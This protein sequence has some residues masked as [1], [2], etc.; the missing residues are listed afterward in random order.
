MEEFCWP[1]VILCS[2]HKGLITWVKPTMSVELMNSHSLNAEVNNVWSL[3]SASI[4]A[5]M[6]WGLRPRKAI[7]LYIQADIARFSP[8]RLG[9]KA[10]T[11]QSWICGGR[12]GSS[13]GNFLL[14]CQLT[15]HQ[16]LIFT[17]HQR[18][19]YHE[20]RLTYIHTK[21]KVY[22]SGL[23]VVTKLRLDLDENQM[24]VKLAT[25]MRLRNQKCAD[26]KFWS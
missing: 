7:Q 14:P 12:I 9:F 22:F 21:Y 1:F 2:W 26:S 20:T 18:P 6:V 5:C 16:L 25:E 3:H 15:F 10:R 19:Q 23:L 17:D 4:S 24:S 13:P 11:L 8:R